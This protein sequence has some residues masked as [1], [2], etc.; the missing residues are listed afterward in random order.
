MLVIRMFCGA[1]MSSS[2]LAK[3][4]KEAGEAM[5][6]EVDMQAHPLDFIKRGDASDLKGIDCALLGPQVAFEKAQLEP[7]FIEAGVPFEVIPMRE[8]GMCDGEAV[9]KLCL[10]MIE[11]NKAK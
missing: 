5:G 2:L 3:K 4:T 11:E 8:Y 7:K 6:Y 1:G 10:K 9:F